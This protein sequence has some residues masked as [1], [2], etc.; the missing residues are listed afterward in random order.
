MAAVAVYLGLDEWRLVEVL[1]LFLVFIDPQLGKHLRYLRR[2]E[3][4]E[5]GVARILCGGREDAHVELLVDVE[6]VADVFSQHAPLVI[7]EVI[8]H[9]QEHLLALIEQREY[10]ALEDVGTHQM[11]VSVVGTHPVEIVLGYVFGETLVSLFLLHAQHLSHRTSRIAQL[12]FPAYQS[13]VNLHQV[14]QYHLIG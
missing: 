11:S 2:H 10:L 5:D 8:Y 14:L 12:Q 1:A 6:Q 4:A 7:A 13:L 9:N 3:A